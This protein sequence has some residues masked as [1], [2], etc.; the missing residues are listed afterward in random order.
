M[1]H[2]VAVVV[3]FAAFQSTV[4]SIIWTQLLIVV[5]PLPFIFRVRENFLSYCVVDVVPGCFTYLFVYIVV[6]S[7]FEG[8]FIKKKRLHTEFLLI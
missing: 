3:V 8:G 1:G 4:S 2:V 5:G 6:L 7:I